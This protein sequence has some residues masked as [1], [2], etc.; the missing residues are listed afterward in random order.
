MSR[1]YWT[2]PAIGERVGFQEEARRAATNMICCIGNV[3][4]GWRA[5]SSRYDTRDNPLSH[6]QM[7]I[8]QSRKPGGLVLLAVINLPAL[9]K[10]HSSSHD[11]SVF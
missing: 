5:K 4:D 10:Q 2:C 3:S 7:D 11:L 1:C 8:R 9:V 6:S